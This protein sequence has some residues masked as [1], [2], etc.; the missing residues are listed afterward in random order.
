MISLRAWC[1]AGL[2]PLAA[3]GCKT[4]QVVA[5]ATAQSAALAEAA[6]L[7]SSR[8]QQETPS[9]AVVAPPVAAVDF[10]DALPMP[11]LQAGTSSG[12]VIGDVL[13]REW[14]QVEVEARNPSLEAMIAAWQ[15]AAQRYP[16]QIALDVVQEGSDAQR[17]PGAGLQRVEPIQRAQAVLG[18]RMLLAHQ[19][20]RRIHQ[21]VAQSVVTGRDWSTYR[22]PSAIAHSMSC[23][24]P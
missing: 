3:V 22:T 10:Q 8:R 12:E 14:L 17:R 15:A 5:P 1:C 13:S 2:L 23:G 4:A 7:V 24:A 19:A 18:V 20:Q 21:T 6:P 11:A 9:A 16:Q